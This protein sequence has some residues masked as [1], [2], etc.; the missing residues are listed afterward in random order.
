MTKQK[1]RTVSLDQLQLGV[2]K[3]LNPLRHFPK[4]FQINHR[5]LFTREVIN[6]STKTE[7]IS[8]IHQNA[9]SYLPSGLLNLSG[10]GQDLEMVLVR[11]EV[12]IS[13]DRMVSPDQELFLYFTHF[14]QN[15]DGCFHGRR[16]CIEGLTRGGGLDRNLKRE[17]TYRESHNNLLV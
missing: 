7:T 3:E 13:W 5:V 9:R 8:R 17:S 15:T 10:K 6:S 11:Q 2:H 1:R 12:Q 16:G 4:F 14:E